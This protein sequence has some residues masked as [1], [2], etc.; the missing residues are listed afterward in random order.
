MRRKLAILAAASVL[1][2]GV[3]HAASAQQTILAFSTMAGVDGAF[4]KNNPIRGVIGDELP[5]DIVGS[6]TGSLTTD[7]H[8]VIHVRGLVFSSDA[9]VPPELRGTNDETQFR[10]L[11]SCLSSG[12]KGNGNVRVV[13][14]TT[15]GFPATTTGDSDIDAFVA[16]PDQ[17]VAP[18]V[19]VLAGSEDKWFAATGAGD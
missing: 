2:L 4:V 13:N 18:I 9:E 10:G 5:W 6:A 14:L 7:G 8:L 1:V 15:A 19:F 16:L 12:K 17:C 11:V 3:A